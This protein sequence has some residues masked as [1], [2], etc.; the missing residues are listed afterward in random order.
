MI[1]R[2]QLTP[3]VERCLRLLGDLPT[4]RPGA[5]G[6]DVLRQRYRVR[7]TGATLPK[8]ELA[9]VRDDSVAGRA[10]PIAIRQYVPVD[11]PDGRYPA[12]LFFHGGGWVSGDLDS[13]DDIC[14]HMAH[15]SGVQVIAVN[16]RLAPENPFPASVEDAIDTY[17]MLL[18]HSARWNIDTGK[19]ALMG[20]GTG[21]TLASVVAIHARDMCQPIPV[22]QL[23]FYPATDLSPKRSPASTDDR[24]FADERVPAEEIDVPCS[25]NVIRW[26][27]GLY[28]GNW[29]DPRDWR[30]SPLHTRSFAGLSPCFIAVGD[31]DPLYREALDFGN[32]LYKAGVT[33]RLRDLPGQING[34]LMLG[35]LLGEAAMS[36]KAAAGFL[37]ECLAE[38]ARAPS[39]GLYLTV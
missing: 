20:D 23:L 1:P 15:V 36:M 38:K 10:G 11:V 26:L 33:V 29:A 32:K 6:L 17:S 14:R 19:I 4:V 2:Q 8:R 37:Q 22:C 16:Y 5:S 9:Q 13:H 12:I 25:R 31:R 30:V 3:E 21:G 35:G 39:R 28:L 24:A 34:F 18:A 7:M 27:H